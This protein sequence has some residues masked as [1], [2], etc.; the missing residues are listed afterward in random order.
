MD[1]SPDLGIILPIKDEQESIVAMLEDI[2]NSLKACPDLKNVLL[3]AV[4]DNS[5]DDGIALLQA[6]HKQQSHKRFALEVLRLDTTHG[7]YMALLR[8]CQ[9]A[10]QFSP[11]Y[12][13]ILDADGQDNPAYIAQLL[14]LAAVSEVVF[15][16][17]GRRKDSMFFQVCYRL[18]QLLM[19][20]CSGKTFYI[21]HYAVLQ[22]HV[23]AEVAKLNYVGFFG[24]LLY[25]SRFSRQYLIADRRERIAG[26]SK[27]MFMQRLQLA[28]TI[29]AYS[30]Q[31]VMRLCYLGISLTLACGLLTFISSSRLWAAL[32]LLSSV[33]T[34][35]ILVLFVNTCLKRIQPLG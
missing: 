29:F 35:S 1:N 31:A 11:R 32:T 9:C 21:S 30:R 10:N 18:F 4:D 7:L 17:R 34:L 8:G 28:L 6:W 33:A 13:V 3:I 2:V 26:K 22:R 16:A 23:L 24:A 27:F 12:T 25:F 20:L 14:E 15:A 19:K 5:K